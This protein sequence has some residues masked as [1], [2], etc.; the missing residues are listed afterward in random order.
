MLRC[1]HSHQHNLPV[2][3]KINPLYNA[4][5]KYLLTIE[6]MIEGWRQDDPPSIPQL[7]V[8]VTVLNTCFISN[9]HFPDVSIQAAGQLTIIAFYYLL[10][11][12]EYTKPH[13][14]IHNGKAV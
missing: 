1:S 13:M 2:G 4:E 5:Q 12:G 11:V 7:A 14:V 9:L 3:W 8:P 10:R 6:R